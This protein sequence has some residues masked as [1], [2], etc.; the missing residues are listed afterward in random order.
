MNAFEDLSAAKLLDCCA[1]SA[2]WL[3]SLGVGAAGLLTMVA[4][5]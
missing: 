2:A 1:V 3:L 4:I 5:G